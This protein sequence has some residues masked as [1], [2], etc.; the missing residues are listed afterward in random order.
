MPAGSGHVGGSS[1]TAGRMQLSLR[2]HL[3]RRLENVNSMHCHL[4][5][6]DCWHVLKI[7]RP[8]SPPAKAVAMAD[9]CQHA[10]NII[11][12]E[13]HGASVATAVIIDVQQD[14]QWTATM[15]LACFCRT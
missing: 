6:V 3:C 1:E 13:T 8:L 12:P 5:V 7:Q 15:L 9:S 10:T 11:T 2:R 14:V 4:F